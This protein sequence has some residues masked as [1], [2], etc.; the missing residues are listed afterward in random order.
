MV[1]CASKLESWRSHFS[2]RE[3]RTRIKR[4]IK[5][6]KVY[7][8]KPEHTVFSLGNMTTAEEIEM[9][10]SS[11]FPLGFSN[12]RFQPADERGEQRGRVKEYVNW[13]ESQNIIFIDYFPLLPLANC[14]HSFHVFS[15]EVR[16]GVLR[17]FTCIRAVVPKRFASCPQKMKLLLVALLVTPHHH[18]HHHYHH[19]HW[20]I[21]WLLYLNKNPRRSLSRV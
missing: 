6:F 14:D 12:Y 18:H 21:F 11:V 3:Q 13:I 19:H 5:S 20:V 8:F 1:Y 7:T 4:G 15:L 17:Q 16:G 10:I 9:R 2:K